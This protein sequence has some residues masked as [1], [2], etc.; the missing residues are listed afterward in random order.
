MVGD[1]E[2]GRQKV[3]WARAHMPILEGVRR[4]FENERPFDGLVV[5]MVLHV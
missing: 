5:S 4:R 3:D 2:R 1:L